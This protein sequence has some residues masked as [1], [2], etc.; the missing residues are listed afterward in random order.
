MVG[1]APPLVLPIPLVFCAGE[2]KDGF[3]GGTHTST[4]QIYNA[5]Y[6]LSDW[7]PPPAATKICQTTKRTTRQIRV[8]IREGKCPLPLKKC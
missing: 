8:Y 6:C 3:A 1:P 5:V 4:S 7:L 2:P